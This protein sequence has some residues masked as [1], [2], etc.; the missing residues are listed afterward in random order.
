MAR[1]AICSF[2][3]LIVLGCAGLWGCA[4][5]ESTVGGFDI[6]K[7]IAQLKVQGGSIES[8]AE[9]IIYRNALQ[10]LLRSQDSLVN[11]PVYRRQI[12]ELKELAAR[13]DRPGWLVLQP[14]KT[15]Y[16]DNRRMELPFTIHR[17]DAVRWHVTVDG[18]ADRIRVFEERTGKTVKQAN[19]SALLDHEFTAEYTDVYTL[20]IE[21]SRPVYAN[22]SIDRKPKD[23]KSYF[24]S[25]DFVVD[26]LPSAPGDKK[27][28]KYD[29]LVMTN[30]FNEPYKVVVSQQLTLSGSPRITI[31][32]ELPK[33]TQEFI[34][35]V[36]ISGEERET[37]D[38]GQLYDKLNTKYKQYKL[39]GV[40]VFESTGTGSS[41]TRELL[42]SIGFPKREKFS[43][44]IYFFDKE[45]DAKNF[46]D[47]SPNGFKYDMKNSIKNSESRNGLIKY[48]GTGFVYLGLES[49]STFNS[50]YAWVD[51]VAAKMETRY[52]RIAKKPLDST[53]Y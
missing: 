29:E 46:V 16:V 21:S 17:G 45:G 18:V 35:Q 14:D 27:A 6:V 5:R 13:F 49:T 9:L 8:E 52:V 42:N 22:V 33:G 11:K 26:T 51:V 48:R 41:L 3:A 30:V 53:S 28:V 38:D 39:I 50:T 31:P 10:E 34:Y 44:N 32:I 37:H 19:N 36:R 15:V 23:A 1:T 20:V 12:N 4:D 47:G 2:F 24:Q 7:S 43:G 40:T 25:T